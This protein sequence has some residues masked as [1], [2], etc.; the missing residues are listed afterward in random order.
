MTIY[1]IDNGNNS[2]DLQIRGYSTIIKVWI[3]VPL[4]ESL[5]RDGNQL[6]II[7]PNKIPLP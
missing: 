4:P 6:L 1:I 2:Q 7:L 3:H 5:N